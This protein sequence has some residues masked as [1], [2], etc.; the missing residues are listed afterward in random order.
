MNALEF[1]T[2]ILGET[3]E[4]R[5]EALRKDPHSSARFTRLF[6]EGIGKD[7]FDF[8]R[9]FNQTDALKVIQDEINL[10]H[11][12]NEHPDIASLDLRHSMFDY[13]VALS[14]GFYFFFYK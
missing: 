4:R 3:D 13:I 7:D 1:V 11:F 12:G 5:L 6:T 8:S 10:L 9:D 2:H 14:N